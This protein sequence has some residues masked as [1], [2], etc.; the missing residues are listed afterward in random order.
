MTFT[1]ISRMLLKQRTKANR[2]LVQQQQEMLG[3][4]FSQQFQV[5][6]K[7]M[8]NHQQLQNTL[9]MVIQSDLHYHIS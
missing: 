5:H 6:G 9:E 3:R 8:F 7:V 4:G 2:H 1:A